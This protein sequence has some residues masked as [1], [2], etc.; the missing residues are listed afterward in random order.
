MSRQDKGQDP[1][2]EYSCEEVSIGMTACHPNIESGITV[3]V[4]CESTGFIV[5]TDI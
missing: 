5:R 2:V 1:K 3:N 4:N